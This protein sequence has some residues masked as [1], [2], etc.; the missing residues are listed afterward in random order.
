M[1]K[2]IELKTAIHLLFFSQE[3]VSP[4]V[5]MILDAI[6][7]ELLLQ[8]VQH[9]AEPV[10]AFRTDTEE[11]SGCNYRGGLLFPIPATL[12]LS[13][14]HV[15]AVSDSGVLFERRVELWLLEDM[16]FAVTANVRVQLCEG[17]FES[18]YR[19]LKT[20]ELDV[21]PRVIDLDLALLAMELLRMSEKYLESSM[22]TY[23]L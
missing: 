15:D 22:P 14:P 17:D 2:T 21:F 4:A 20:R 13:V 1:L 3:E 18:E 5:Q 10:Y 12:L 9:N 16:S 7:Y 11:E 19:T 8:S 23:E 6:D